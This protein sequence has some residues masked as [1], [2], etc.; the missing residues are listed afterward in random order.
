MPAVFELRRDPVTGWWSA[1]VTDRAFEHASFAVE[2][3]QVEGSHCRHCDEA[4]PDAPPHQVRRVPLRA[5]AF[6]RID[7]SKESAA[8]LAISEVER[9]SGS[10]EILVGP[11]G[12]HERL[13]DA[14]PQLA[15]GMLRA[16]RDAMR[17][18]GGVPRNID[19]EGR[20]EALYVQ[21]VQSY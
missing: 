12:H 17:D 9:S 3:Q 10:W 20:P 14:A 21:L 1:I 16:A 8:Q 11:A 2:A 4:P 6:H 19:A 13:A 15:G 18:L 5:N 7:S